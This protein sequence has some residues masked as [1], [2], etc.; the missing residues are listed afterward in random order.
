MAGDP[1][2]GP[3]AAGDDPIRWLELAILGFGT[4]LAMA[5]S[6]SA[7]AVAP[8]LRTEWASGRSISRG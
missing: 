4:L 5:P 7:S 1:P 6:F 8:L 2:D 3:A